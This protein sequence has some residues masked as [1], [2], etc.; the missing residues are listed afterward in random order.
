MVMESL[1][2]KI[3]VLK[4]CSIIGRHPI[5]PI[6][7]NTITS[8]QQL[9]LLALFH[10]SM[11]YIASQQNLAKLQEYTSYKTKASHYHRL[12]VILIIS[13]A[14]AYQVLPSPLSWEDFLRLF[15]SPTYPNHS[16]TSSSPPRLLHSPYPT[17]PHLSHLISPYHKPLL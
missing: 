12:I 7:Y 3:L 6:M 10:L 13:T 11:L 16:F 5:H 8:L 17:S 15:T 14:I 1:L 4:Y 9:S 2:G